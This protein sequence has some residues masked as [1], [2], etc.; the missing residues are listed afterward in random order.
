MMKHYCAIF[1]IVTLGVRDCVGRCTDKVSYHSE[2]CD[3]FDRFRDVT[4]RVIN[5]EEAK[6]KHEEKIDALTLSLGQKE[7]QIN[8]LNNKDELKDK[9]IQL[10]LTQVE[11]LT[12]SLDE[13][14]EQINKL[15]FNDELKNDTIQQLTT[16]GME[17]SDYESQIKDSLI[18]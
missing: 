1:L 2:R 15:I 4:D 13:K 12:I 5:L 7:D 10:L 9:T 6:W 18:K 3:I 17:F 16:E 11:K 8:E 14:E